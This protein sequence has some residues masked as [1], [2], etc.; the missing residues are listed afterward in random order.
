MSPVDTAW[1]RMDSPGNLMM[2]VGVDVFDGRVDAARLRELLRSHLLCWREFRSRVVQDAT[3]A[4]WQEDDELDLDQHLVHIRLPG[5][6]GTPEL[7]QLVGQLAGQP[8]DPERPLWQMHLVENFQRGHALILRIHH[9][10]ADGIALVGV[11]LG[12]TTTDPDA[13]VA[14]PVRRKES[15][16]PASLIEQWL[17][18]ITAAAVRVLNATGEVASSFLRG[19]RQVLGDSDLAAQAAVQLTRTAAQVTRDVA[20]LAFMASDTPTRLKG[21]PGGVKRVAWNEPLPLSDV[22][23]V[24]KAMGCSVNDVLLACVAGSLR[25]YLV[26]FGDEV[27]G[28][29]LRAMVPVNL[30]AP[31][32]APSLGN[33]FGLVPLLWATVNKQSSILNRH[34]NCGEVQAIR[35]ARR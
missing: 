2:I 13:P 34:W 32:A 8:L 31:G 14:D 15:A 7:Q 18:P 33:K 9:C 28:A 4:W 23:A 22:K 24:G 10:I 3:G 19:Y 1:L 21:R 26:A 35:E 17:K 16:A 5:R 12:M 6:A 20:A 27:E 30:R 29:E 25:S 11:T